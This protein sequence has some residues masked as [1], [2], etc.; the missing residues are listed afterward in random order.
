MLEVIL[1]SMISG[2]WNVLLSM[3]GFISYQQSV[4]NGSVVG[5]KPGCCYEGNNNGVNLLRM[6]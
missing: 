1:F 5:E 3:P 6:P 2:K 4:V